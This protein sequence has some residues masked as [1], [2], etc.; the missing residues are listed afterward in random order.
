MSVM[1]ALKRF[2][3]VEAKVGLISDAH[4][5]QQAEQ[6]GRLV[7]R[8]EAQ[9]IALLRDRTGAGKTLV[10]LVTAQEMLKKG[11]VDRVVVV[12]PNQR[13]DQRW[14]EGHWDKF[15]QSR[16]DIEFYTRHDVTERG[17]ARPAPLGHRGLLIV[18]ESHRGLQSDGAQSHAL[19][20]LSD[21]SYVLLVS[22]TP[23]QLSTGGL[24]NMLELSGKTL[25]DRAHLE[26]YG[27]AVS[28]LLKA[29]HRSTRSGETEEVEHAQAEVANAIA[30]AKGVLDAVSPPLM[31]DVPEVGQPGTPEISVEAAWLRA[32]HVA[33]VIPELIDGQRA[34]DMFR[35][36]LVSSSEAFWSGQVGRLLK[37]LAA[38]AHAAP[39]VDL[40]ERD[41]GSGAEH[42]K[43]NRTA[44]LVRAQVKV[45]H[46]VLVFCVFKETQAALYTAIKAQFS[47]LRFEVRAPEDLK[48]LERGGFL[49]RFRTPVAKG[50]RACVIVARDN[51]SESFDLDG[52]APSLI[53]HDLPWNPARLTQRWGR[54]VR[55][56]SGFFPVPAE[57]HLAPVLPVEVDLRMAAVVRQR[58]RQ[59]ELMLPGDCAARSDDAESVPWA[60]LLANAAAMAR[61]DSA[62]P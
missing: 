20:A 8:L 54:V 24:L 32:F 25:P 53:H 43:V 59:G 19:K 10:A 51:L 50:K 46:H 48:A 47:S 18:D 2:R 3:D 4:L 62:V 12:S 56:S 55:R 38:Q 7:E 49:E 36:R 26:H 58:T 17:G 16:D 6:V 28:R 29:W 23:F 27:R 33:Q 61:G 41:L 37:E 52:G 42:P 22:A 30:S 15:A 60:S 9:R 39:L 44:E 34:G 45:G 13:V 57:R 11:H 35:R 31:K 14:S 40:L 21:G 5:E 1:D